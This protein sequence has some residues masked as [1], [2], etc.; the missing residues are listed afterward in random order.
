MAK[1][2]KKKYPSDSELLPEIENFIFNSIK[3]ADISD[4]KI[5]DI[6]LVVAEA[7]ANSILH[8]NKND[9][10][11]F[12]EIKIIMSDDEILISFTDEGQGFKPDK[13]PDP[14]HPE[15]IFKGSGRGI[16]I[17]R[18]LVDKIEYKFRKNGTELIL[19]FKI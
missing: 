4:Q 9:H 7:A 3:E 2:I 10:N 5:N 17:M 15:N 14:T 12:V 1:K 8:G 11:K 18:N 13:V 6:E 16:H 19:I